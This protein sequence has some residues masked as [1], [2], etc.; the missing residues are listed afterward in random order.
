MTV[1]NTLHRDKIKTTSNAPGYRDLSVRIEDQNGCEHEINL[2]PQDTLTLYR[3]CASALRLA[4][5]GGDG[6]LDKQPGET[7]PRDLA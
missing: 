2:D 5:N 6:P 3:A 4:W 7:R 1:G